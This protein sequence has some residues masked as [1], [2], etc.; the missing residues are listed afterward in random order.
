MGMAFLSV[1]GLA[2][3]ILYLH[4][5]KL[6]LFHVHLSLQE[7]L[8]CLLHSIVVSTSQPK[9]PSA[10]VHFSYSRPSQK[11]DTWQMLT[12][13]HITSWS[14]KPRCIS[15]WFSVDK[16]PLQAWVH[17]LTAFTGDCYLQVWACALSGDVIT[18]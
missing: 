13:P 15:L 11:V 4:N 6:L 18:R 9:Q 12:F 10:Y 16:Y 2:I 3:D 1:L 5:T 7:S 17:L 8:P 14:A